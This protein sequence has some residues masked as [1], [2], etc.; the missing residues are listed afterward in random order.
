LKDHL[1]ADIRVEAF[2]GNYHHSVKLAGNV[3]VMPIRFP[4][5][6]FVPE[7]QRSQQHIEAAVFY[8][9][10]ALLLLS[11]GLAIFI[12]NPT[13]YQLRI[14][15]GLFAIAMGAFALRLTGMLTVRLTFGQKVLISATGALA[16]FVLVY[17]FIPKQ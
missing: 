7:D 1:D 9:G 17:F 12:P 3:D 16:V 14:F 11:I 5:V 10:V 6:K 13:T 2:Y 4:E 15:T 8:C